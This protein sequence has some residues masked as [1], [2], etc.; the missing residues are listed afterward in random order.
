MH[1]GEIGVA[2]E[3]GRGS[4]FQFYVKT[5]RTAQSLD[6]PQTPDFQL[7]VR[8]DALREACATEISA[9]H[10][11]LSILSGAGT[12]PFTDRLQLQNGIKMP[13]TQPETI[14][15]ISPSIHNSSSFYILVVEDNLVNQK[16]ACKQLRKAGHVVSVANHGEEALDF[17][18]RSEYWHAVATGET[19]CGEPLSVILMDLEMPVMDGVTCFR[20]IRELQVLGKIMGHV[21]VIAVTANARKDQIIRSLEAGMVSF[22]SFVP[23]PPLCLI[24]FWL[25]W[26][27]TDKE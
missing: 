14:R 22:P 27:E 2:S 6:V 16:V 21:P 20:K 12:D 3:T 5:R 23:T 19:E 9:V 1:G 26:Y 4:T 25:E 7:L 17:I 15:S 10:I 11:T 13:N 8:E 18:R 24:F